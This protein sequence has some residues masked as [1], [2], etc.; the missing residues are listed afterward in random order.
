MVESYVHRFCRVNVLQDYMI[1]LDEEVIPSAD[2]L[3][4]FR[5]CYEVLATDKSLT[6]VSAWNPYGLS[7]L[8]HHERFTTVTTRQ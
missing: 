2:F 1:F 5:Q 4:F 3:N 6:G 8:E 7:L